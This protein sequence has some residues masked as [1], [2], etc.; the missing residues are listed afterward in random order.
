MAKTNT[1]KNFLSGM[2]NI[3]PQKN[4]S[5][6]QRIL[7]IGDIHLCFYKF[8][9][10]WKKLN[11]TDNDLCIFLGDYIDRNIEGDKMLAWIF[12]HSNKENFVFL[13]GNHELMFVD[14]YRQDRE[15]LNK[16]FRG[17][18]TQLTSQDVKEHEA[19][20]FW[21]LNGGDK[22]INA[23]LRLKQKN[24]FIVDEFLTF[25]KNLDFSY[26]I[27]ICGRTYFFCHAGIRPKVP[28]EEQ[29]VED[30]LW[31]RKEF[32]HNSRGYNG[33]DV[34]IVGHTPTQR[35]SW[36]DKDRAVLMTTIEDKFLVDH[37]NPKKFFDNNKPFAMLNRN[38]LMV[39]TGSWRS[40]ISAVD[41]ISGQY[42]QSD[43]NFIEE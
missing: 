14:A 5:P 42:W 38:I 17:E 29:T 4:D 30:L 43:E 12:E 23:L 32:F 8:M 37:V 18:K 3:I 28:L 35:L 25:V 24:E 19:A 27:E 31:I 13:A 7:A 2:E 21:I 40:S 9:S 36:S 34:I 6:Y 1:P 11:V 33:K 26:T 41:V 15:L 16:I 20:A 39:D 10:L 22:T